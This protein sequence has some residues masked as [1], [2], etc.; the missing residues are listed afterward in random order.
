MEMK[1]ALDGPEA[2]AVVAVCEMGAEGKV[3][4]TAQRF[5]PQGECEGQRPLLAVQA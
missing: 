1:A 5:A 3:Q 4:A 2:Y